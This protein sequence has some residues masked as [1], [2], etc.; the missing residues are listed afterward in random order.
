MLLSFHNIWFLSTNSFLISFLMI[1]SVQIRWISVLPCVLSGWLC[2]R[3]YGFR[4]KQFP[5]DLWL[6]LRLSGEII[7][8]EKYG[9]SADSGAGSFDMQAVGLS[10]QQV[11]SRIKE[12]ATSLIKGLP[13]KLQVSESD[14][15]PKSPVVRSAL[16]MRMMKLKISDSYSKSERKLG[17]WLKRIN[18]PCEI[19]NLVSN[20]GAYCSILL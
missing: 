10:L 20:D 14:E 12:I 9:L 19:A 16:L 5:S 7:L 11:F 17:L 8:W 4:N 15:R 2:E 18:L 1:Q 6:R 13:K 3:A